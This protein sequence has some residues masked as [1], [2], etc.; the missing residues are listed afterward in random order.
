MKG[1]CVKENYAMSTLTIQTMIKNEL[2][3]EIKN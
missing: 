2:K 3:T 1:N